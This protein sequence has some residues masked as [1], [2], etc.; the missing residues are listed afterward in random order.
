MIVALLLIVV[1]GKAHTLVA[2]GMVIR[3]SARSE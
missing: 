2:D 1:K 3:F